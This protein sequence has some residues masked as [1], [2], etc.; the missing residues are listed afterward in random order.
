M[1]NLLSYSDGERTLLEI[2]ELIGAPVW[3]LREIVGQLQA[4]GLIEIS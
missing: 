1:M 4:A 2:A 3:R